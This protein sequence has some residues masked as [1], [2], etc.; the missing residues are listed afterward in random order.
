MKTKIKR[1]KKEYITTEEKKT[2][3]PY[4]LISQEMLSNFVVDLKKKFAYKNR[5]NQT[6][7]KDK[8]NFLNRRK[9]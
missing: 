7:K 8:N 1:K 5:L 9:T 4:K 2:A 3:R 6:L